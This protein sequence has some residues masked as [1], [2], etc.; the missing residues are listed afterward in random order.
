MNS[1]LLNK[2]LPYMI[3]SSLLLSGCGREKAECFEPNEHVHLYTKE[4][5]DGTIVSRYQDCEYLNDHDWIWNEDHINLTHNEIG[6]AYY[7]ALDSK[8]LFDGVEYFDYLYNK[9]ANDHDYLEYYYRYTEE[10]THTVTDEDGNETTYTTEETRQ[11]WSTDKTHR[12]NTGEVRLCHHQYYAYKPLLI[13]GKWKLFKSDSVDDVR[14]V[15]EYYPFV[16]ED[17]STIVTKTHFVSPF[18]LRTIEAIDFYDDFG[19]PD[20]ENK[21]SSVKNKRTR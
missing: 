17:F 18:Q 1:K 10:T 12:G 14:E 16:G 21:E 6:K 20:L 2:I 15:L 11:G 5:N 7:D 9:M 8:T 13:D 19:H 4:M 3:M